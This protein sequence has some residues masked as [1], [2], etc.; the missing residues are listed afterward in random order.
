MSKKLTRNTSQ[1]KILSIQLGLNGF[2]FLILDNKEVFYAK[3]QLWQ[4]ESSED[5]LTLLENTLEQEEELKWDYAKTVIVLENP[6]FFLIPDPW[7]D[8]QKIKDHY[9]FHFPLTHTIQL[10][11]EQT[12]RGDWLVYA[13]EKELE[14]ILEKHFPERHLTHHVKASL[15]ASHDK[16]NNHFQVHVAADFISI[17][18]I[19]TSDRLL[20][21]NSYKTKTQDDLLYH[22]LYPFDNLGLDVHETIVYLQ[23]DTSRILAIL[24]KLKKYLPKIKVKTISNRKIGSNIKHESE[25]VSLSEAVS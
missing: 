12:E 7:Y 2:S 22:I 19:D 1:T 14:K 25:F 13:I 18:L 10:K 16:E 20:L 24:P 11:S 8:P 15:V 6:N 3:T 17:S 5:Y 21:C 9:K 23:G 4:N